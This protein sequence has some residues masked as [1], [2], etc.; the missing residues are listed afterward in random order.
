MANEGMTQ[1]RWNALTQAQRDERQELSGL[2]PQLLGLEGWRVEVDTS[3]GETRRFIVGRSTGWR[4]CHIEL[5][6]RNSSSGMAASKD[7]EKVTP[8]YQ[9]HNDPRGTHKQ[10]MVR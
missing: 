6:R 10:G 9:A 4:P 8:L 2:T 7:Y 1:Q 5:H 3:Y